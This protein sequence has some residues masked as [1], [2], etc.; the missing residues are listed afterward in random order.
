[1][2]IKLATRNP[3]GVCPSASHR[4]APASC[5]P[6]AGPG[7]SSKGPEA[8]RR[9]PAGPC[10]AL[11]PAP[12][13]GH[14]RGVRVRGGLSRPIERALTAKRWVRVRP[15][16]CG[17]SLLAQGVFRLYVYGGGSAMGRGRPYP[18][19]FP[20]PRDDALEELQSSDQMRRLPLKTW[21]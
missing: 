2:G 13:W 9:A 7:G 20:S 12:P 21:Q 14:S 18:H 15:P 19:Q 5:G 3:V 1:M 16:A 17:C 4:D 11:P 10:R 8:K 6:S